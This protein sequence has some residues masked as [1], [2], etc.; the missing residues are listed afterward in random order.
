MASLIYVKKSSIH[1]KGLFARQRIGRREYIGCYRGKVTTRNG[2]Y[3]LWVLQDDG[4][5]KGVDGRNSLR[6]LNHSS[7]PNAEFWG[8]MLFAVRVIRPHDE[9]TI[10]YGPSWADV[11]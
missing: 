8:D 7:R 10:D 9:I 11:E 6:Y 1:G 4:S 3:V 2:R 5:V